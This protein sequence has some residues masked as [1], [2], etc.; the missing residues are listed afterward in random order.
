MSTSETTGTLAFAG[1]SVNVLGASGSTLHG[2]PVPTSIDA[3]NGGRLTTVTTVRNNRARLG[4]T[5]MSL[6]SMMEA[7]SRRG[8]LNN[9]ITA[10]FI[11]AAIWVL[12]T[13]VDKMR[14][15]NAAP[16]GKSVAVQYADPAQATVTSRV[17]FD[18]SIDG[19]SAGRV[20]IGLFGDDLPKTVEN[21]EKLAT[22]ELGFGYKGSIGMFSRSL[23]LSQ[24][25]RESRFRGL[26]P[27]I[28]DSLFSFVVLWIKVH[29]VIKNFMAQGG[30]FT[31]S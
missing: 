5:K 1:G 19:K 15:A 7:I 10:G 30:D 14:V 28:S 13:P 22:G 26:N 9:L 18:I 16:R 8:L 24:I 17:F 29:R 20:V 12:A 25:E 31:V 6:S 21:F 3:R 23:L 4:M 2:R 11:G 27:I